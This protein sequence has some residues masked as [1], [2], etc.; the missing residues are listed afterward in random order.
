MQA[1]RRPHRR[2]GFRTSEDWKFFKEE[3]NIAALIQHGFND[4]RYLHTEMALVVEKLDD[5]DGRII[6]SNVGSLF[7]PKRA[8]A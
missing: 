3:F 5:G 7:G 1:C 2:N 6:R 4:R 8:G